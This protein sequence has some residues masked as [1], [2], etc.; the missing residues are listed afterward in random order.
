M[1]K[2]PVPQDK[3]PGRKEQSAFDEIKRKPCNMQAVRVLFRAQDIHKAPLEPTPNVMAARRKAQ[4]ELREKAAQLEMEAKIKEAEAAIKKREAILRN[5]ANQ[6]AQKD[7]KHTWIARFLKQRAK[8][9]RKPAPTTSEIRQ[10][11]KDYA[12]GKIRF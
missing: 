8:H 1:K 7:S 10:A 11:Q 6:E 5:R 4:A 3:V 9:L 2:K 12:A